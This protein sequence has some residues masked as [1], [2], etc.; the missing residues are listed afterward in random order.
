MAHLGQLPQVR[1]PTV[2]THET[3]ASQPPLP[4]RH[5][6]GKRDKLFTLAQ[7]QLQAGPSANT[8]G[9][10]NS[11]TREATKSNDDSH[12]VDVLAARDTLA[13]ANVAAAHEPKTQTS[14]KVDRARHRE[15]Q[16]AKQST[17]QT[18]VGAHNSVQPANTQREQ[19]HE[20]QAEDTQPSTESS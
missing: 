19:T 12:L 8:N 16:I 10:R 17:E 14:R 15:A 13:R 3:R 2:F 1:E 7:K 6:K 11:R 20:G 4:V 18:T 5:C 9:A